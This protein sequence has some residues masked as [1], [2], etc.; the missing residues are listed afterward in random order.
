[1]SDSSG[2]F[3]SR[4]LFLGGRHDPMRKGELVALRWRD[5]DFTAGRVHVRRNYTC[6]EFG[7]SP[8]TRR[9]TRSVPLAPDLADA[10]ALRATSPWTR[11]DDLVFARPEHGGVLPK[12]NIPRRFRAALRAA[13]IDERYSR[14]PISGQAVA[15]AMGCGGR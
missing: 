8:K 5:V 9:S 6:G 7:T 12:A 1:M 3:A 11:L 10:L 14:I 4:P 2:Q 13:G 15:S